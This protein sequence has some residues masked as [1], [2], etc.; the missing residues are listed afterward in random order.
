MAYVYGNC[1]IGMS[2][3]LTGH[4]VGANESK[5]LQNRGER[6]IEKDWEWERM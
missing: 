6:K 3:K 1:L 5:E 2:K 4:A